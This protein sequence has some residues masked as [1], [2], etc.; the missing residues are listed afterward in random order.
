MTKRFKDN[1]LV[2]EERISSWKELIEL[3]DSYEKTWMFRGHSSDWN[4]D[5]SLHRV[6]DRFGIDR[7]DA[8]Q[9]EYALMRSFKRKYIGEDSQMIRDDPM[10]CMA[11]MQHYGA[12][13]RLLDWTYSFFVAL[14]FAIESASVEKEFF[15]WAFNYEWIKEK[16]EK[17]GLQSWKYRNVDETRGNPSLFEE[18]YYKK[19][20]RMIFAESALGLN[21]RL[22]DQQGVFI[23]PGIVSES[24]DSIFNHQL[25][26]ENVMQVVKITLAKDEFA[27]IVNKLN[28]MRLTHK[29][30]YSDLEWLGRDLI[31]EV[32]ALKIRNE[33][34]ELNE[35]N[36]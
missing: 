16:L 36:K 32:P 17:I 23:L 4:L 19:E 10:Y 30:I 1:L 7:S 8:F 13:T 27:K 33:R 14:Y 20:N 15:I 29:T 28:R 5:S 3:E 6:C 9:V 31:L 18:E 25:D 21:P 24:I 22:V 35:F 12:P 34:I 11:K 2:K 26:K